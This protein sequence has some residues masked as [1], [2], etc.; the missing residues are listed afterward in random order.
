M[1]GIHRNIKQNF[2][3]FQGNTPKLRAVILD[4]VH[5][6]WSDLRLLD[7]INGLSL[8]F[9]HGIEPSVC[10]PDLMHILRSTSHL[11]DVSVYYLIM[12]DLF[13]RVDLRRMGPIHSHSLTHPSLF[14]DMEAHQW[15]ACPSLF[16]CRWG[17]V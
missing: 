6:S 4:S 11:T 5:L 14:L 3:I 9:S 10:Y 2:V 13:T 15:K 1:L 17:L 8:L 7:C 16:L 12:N